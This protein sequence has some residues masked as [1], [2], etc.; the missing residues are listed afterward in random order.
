MFNPKEA[1]EDSHALNLAILVFVGL[2]CLLSIYIHYDSGL[3]YW[4]LKKLGEETPAV[5]LGFQQAGGDRLTLQEALHESPRDTFK[6]STHFITHGVLVAEINPSGN[7]P[8]VLTFRVPDA[9]MADLQS[10]WIDVTYLGANPKIAHPTDLLE[11]FHFDGR[12]LVWSLLIGAV[13]LW[14]AI[15]SARKW[16]SF[17]NRMRHY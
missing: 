12:V 1:A 14:F 16:S 11:T 3:K 5:V 17:R 2:A 4:L 13:V 10:D 9:W 7:Y 8:Q 6:N 15:R